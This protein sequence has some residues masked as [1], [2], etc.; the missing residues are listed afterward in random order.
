MFPGITHCPAASKSSSSGNSRCSSPVGRICWISPS[1]I[2]RS[3]FSK[4]WLGCPQVIIGPFVMITCFS[5]MR[6]SVRLYCLGI[7]CLPSLGYS[8]SVSSYSS[9]STPLADLGCTNAI[10]RPGR[11]WAVSLIRRTP[12]RLSCASMASI[13]LTSTHT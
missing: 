8:E 3:C 5:L 13:S 9:I 1:R 2:K 10:F 11:I 4:I 12:A 6:R 7:A